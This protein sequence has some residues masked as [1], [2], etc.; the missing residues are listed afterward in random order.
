[1][2]PL[3]ECMNSIGSYHCVCPDSGYDWDSDHCEGKKKTHLGVSV[4]LDSNE[5]EIG[6][7]KKHL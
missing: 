5:W 3:A 4:S 6:H 1:M 2:D 7:L